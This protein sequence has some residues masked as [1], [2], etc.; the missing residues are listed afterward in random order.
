MQ[1]LYCCFTNWPTYTAGK[2]KLRKEAGRSRL[3]SG[4]PKSKGTYLRGCLE[5][6]PDEEI[7]ASWPS[8]YKCIE[9]TSILLQV[10]RGVQFR[11][12]TSAL[13]GLC[14]QN[15]FPCG[16]QEQSMHSLDSGGGQEPPITWVQLPGH[17]KVTCPEWPP[18]G[19]VHKTLT[20]SSQHWPHSEYPLIGN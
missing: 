3:G 4:S 12:E 19:S 16:N 14:P 9:R 13:S 5:E 8:S 10:Y 11:V 15:S 7:W 17:L 1:S 18:P 20:E 2:E 6:P